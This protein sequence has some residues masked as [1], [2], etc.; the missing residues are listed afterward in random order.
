[1][2]R[3]DL[4][5]TPK[6]SEYELDGVKLKELEF[7][8]DGMAVTY[9]SPRGWDYSGNSNQ[10]TL[11]PPGKP[12][13]EATITRTRLEQPGK[14][15]EESLKRLV[16]DVVAQLPKGSD[17]VKVVSQ[18]KN[19]LMIQRKETFLIVLTY[20]I[21]AEKYARSILLLNRGN[22]QIR[23]QLTCYEPDFKELQ[24]AF[25]RSQYTWQHL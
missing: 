25:M 11:R 6:L 3:A 1:M 17:D 22:E 2:A 24:A 15:D 21:Y 5:L 7:A 18:E 10:L 20:T 8:D 14:F 19:P 23:S 9:Q 4:Q 13:A 12:H 16:E